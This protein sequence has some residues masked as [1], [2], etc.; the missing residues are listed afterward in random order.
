MVANA[1]AAAVGQITV[2]VLKHLQTTGSVDVRDKDLH[3]FRY[4]KRVRISKGRR[5]GADEHAH[6]RSEVDDDCA[7]FKKLGAR[8]EQIVH[9]SVHRCEAESSQVV[10]AVGRKLGQV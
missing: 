7:I 4:V 3:V 2:I 8:D 5:S 9:G 10:K 1:R 6:S